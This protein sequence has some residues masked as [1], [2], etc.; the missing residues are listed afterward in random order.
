M[1]L[2][3]LEALATTGV[4]ITHASLQYAS[5]YSSVY[6]YEAMKGSS[7]AVSKPT[8]ACFLKLLNST[9]S[10]MVLS[11]SLCSAFLP[12]FMRVLPLK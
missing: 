5:F 4:C 6:Y 10:S 8:T 1:L 9:I 3:T 12:L 2:G 11:L 7:L